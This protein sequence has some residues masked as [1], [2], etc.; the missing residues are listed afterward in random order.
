MKKYADFLL[1]NLG[2]K[3]KKEAKA[4]PYNAYT[5]EKGMHLGEWLDPEEFQEKISAGKQPK[6]PEEATAY[7]YLDMTTMAEIAELLD[8]DPIT[9][10]ETAEG[11]RKAYN[12][13]FVKTCT[14]DTDRQAKLVQPL[15]LVLL[16][17]ESK[18]TAQ[19]RLAKAA[20]DC[21]YHVGTGFLSTVF[22]LPVLTEAGEVE[23]AYKML[24]NT[25]NPAG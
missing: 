7:L 2:I 25:E 6:H 9:Y 21:H 24:G 11:A 23:T 14:L 5:Y 18:K 12:H 16:D 13:L 3:D 4:N 17:G 22:L 1:S 15:A 8:K 19:R 20:Q 10:R